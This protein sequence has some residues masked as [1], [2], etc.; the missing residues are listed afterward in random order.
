M[1]KSW[2]QRQLPKSSYRRRSSGGLSR[3]LKLADR[4]RGAAAAGHGTVAGGSQHLRGA[5]TSTPPLRW[6]VSQRA[7]SSRVF[8]RGDP[9]T[10]KIGVNPPFSGSPIFTHAPRDSEHDVALKR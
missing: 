6:G 9:E 5:E 3:D 7:V 4:R 10:S 1:V 2:G 8:Q